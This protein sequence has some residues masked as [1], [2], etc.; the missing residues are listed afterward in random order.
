[1]IVWDAFV[2]VAAVSDSLGYGLTQ[3]RTVETVC[4]SL[5]QFGTVWSSLEQFGTCQ[6]SLRRFRTIDTVWDSWESVRNDVTV[7]Q[8]LR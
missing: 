6:Y 8:M 1:M 3:F 2:Y 7:W 5:E 4:D